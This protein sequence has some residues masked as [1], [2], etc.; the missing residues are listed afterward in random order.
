[1][2][3]IEQ[4]DNAYSR[5]RH[6][7]HIDLT[8]HPYNVLQWQSSMPHMNMNVIHWVTVQVS[9]M[10]QML[11][12]K[13]WVTQPAQN[14]GQAQCMPT[15]HL[16]Y[17]R[18]WAHGYYNAGNYPAHCSASSHPAHCSEDNRDVSQLAGSGTVDGKETRRQRAWRRAPHLQA[19]QR[20]PEVSQ[21]PMVD[22]GT[23]AG[24]MLTSSSGK[25]DM[26]S[27]ESRR[28]RARRAHEQQG[29]DCNRTTLMIRN[30]PIR[31]TTERLE[32]QLE[33]MGLAGKYDLLH[34]P[35]DAHK[36]DC[37]LGYAFINL[38][39]AAVA[40]QVERAA[41]GLSW[42]SFSNSEKVCEVEFARV[43]G[44]EALKRRFAQRTR[45]A[46]HAPHLIH[47]E[48]RWW[49]LPETSYAS[50]L[51]FFDSVHGLRNVPLRKKRRAISSS[52]HGHFATLC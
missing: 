40:S 1:M 14:C 30:L 31:I 34:I 33:Q 23:S 43:Q 25:K 2:L 51:R 46:V 3:F 50:D 32:Q 5:S 8:N 39:D 35:R 42:A 36:P 9:T 26:P 28:G 48:A 27:S 29:V 6:S 20:L 22:C 12:N 16:D 41:K 52:C 19:Q 7:Y 13:D 44:L 49:K 15:R 17:T 10:P 38:R 18:Q 45:D 24:N 21:A 37:S 47:G 4:L 11:Y